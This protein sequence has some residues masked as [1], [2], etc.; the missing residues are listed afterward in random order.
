MSKLYQNEAWLKKRFIMD[1][2]T[3][4]QIAQECGVSTETVYV[5]L[6]KFNLKKSR[7]K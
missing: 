3:P 2:R 7:R 4:E 6:S 5:Y 1:K